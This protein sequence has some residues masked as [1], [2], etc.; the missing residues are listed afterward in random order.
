MRK[1]CFGV[2]NPWMHPSRF[3][4]AF[5][6]FIHGVPADR[7]LSPHESHRCCPFKVAFEQDPGVLEAVSEQSYWKSPCPIVNA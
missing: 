5:Y 7:S 6:L 4:S 2:G 3:Y 1:K